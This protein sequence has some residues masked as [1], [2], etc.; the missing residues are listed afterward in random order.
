M[1]KGEDITVDALYNLILKDFLPWLREKT[2]FPVIFFNLTLKD[3]VCCDWIEKLLYV[4]EVFG[5][6]IH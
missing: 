1:F 6:L 2:L 3:L 5:Y 4:H